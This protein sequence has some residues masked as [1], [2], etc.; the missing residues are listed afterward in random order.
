MKF[1]NVKHLG[2]T[3]EHNGLLWLGLSGSGIEFEATGKSAFITLVGDRTA[4]ADWA[5][6]DRARYAVYV[7]GERLVDECMKSAEKTITLFISDKPRTA[8]I[9]VLK[10]SEAPMSLIAIKG[11]TADEIR[12]VA[13]KKLRVEIIGDSITCGYGVDAKNELEEFSTSTEDVTRAYSYKTVTDLDADY[14]F[15]SY[16]GHGI[17]SGYTGEGIKKESELVPPY[18]EKFAFSRGGTDDFNAFDVEWDFSRFVPELVVINL[19]TND[20]S[21]CL[22]KEDRINEYIERYE[23]FLG[24]VR[25]RNKNAV[26]LCILGLMGTSL[27]PA[28]EK[29]VENFRRKTGDKKVFSCR[30]SDQNPENGYGANYHPT[31]KNHRI[32]ADELLKKIREIMTP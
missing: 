14:S 9:K 19:G 32:A 16:S 21:Y 1:S 11:I 12:P 23:E 3:C 5:D 22:D 15:V 28:V 17:I 7:D 4:A 10:L 30:L 26:I 29:T 8:V 6:A 27:C 18:Y 13:P 2:R 31:E 24:V 25:K 20:A